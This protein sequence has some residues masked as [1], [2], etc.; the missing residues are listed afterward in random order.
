MSVGI[1]LPGE[2]AN[3]NLQ[4]RLLMQRNQFSFIWYRSNMG[5]TIEQYR[6]RISTYNNS[7]R[8]K[9]LSRFKSIFWITKGTLIVLARSL[10]LLGCIVYV[11]L[12]IPKNGK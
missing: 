5:I 9:N 2:Q 6:A 10:Y 4:T 12:L 1:Y 3:V 11:A 7:V 8:A